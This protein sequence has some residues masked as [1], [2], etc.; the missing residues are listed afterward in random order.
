MIISNY[1]FDF[2]IVYLAPFVG[3]PIR[4]NPDKYGLEILI[5]DFEFNAVGMSTPICKPY[6]MSLKE[7]YILRPYTRRMI[8]SFLHKK[9]SSFSPKDIIR[10][11]KLLSI[12]KS[13]L[14]LS[15][16]FSQLISIR[17]YFSLA[18]SQNTVFD[19]NTYNHKSYYPLRLWNI[20]YSEDIGYFFTA[21][22]GEKSILT[23]TN[24]ELWRLASGKNSVMEIYQEIN[25][26]E[27]VDYDCII[28]FYKDLE[29]KLALIFRK[30]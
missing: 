11:F 30:H 26:N 15:Q 22:N 17:R 16:V 20:E 10:A 5:D 25:R 28:A 13:N 24:V 3:T 19:D 9:I 4:L 23:N 18:N 27:E 29:S 21:L 12:H 2:N 6:K 1:K 8:A 7:F 14:M